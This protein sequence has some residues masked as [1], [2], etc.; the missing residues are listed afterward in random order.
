MQAMALQ[1]NVVL[2]VLRLCSLRA[3]SIEVLSQ[4]EEVRLA[5]QSLMMFV[6]AQSQA[7]AG[8]IS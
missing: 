7:I 5:F 3:R 6:L 4:C 1:L 8:K 2:A